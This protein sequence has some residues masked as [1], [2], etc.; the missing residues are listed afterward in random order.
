MFVRRYFVLVF[1]LREFMFFEFN[2]DPYYNTNKYEETL[3]FL[4]NDF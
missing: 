4:L 3:L 2:L 1:L